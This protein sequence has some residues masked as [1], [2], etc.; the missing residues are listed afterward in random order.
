MSSLR[1]WRAR[2]ARPAAPQ[3]SRAASAVASASSASAAARRSA[4]RTGACGSLG[5][6]G[7]R[8]SSCPSRPSASAP[9]DAV[10]TATSESKEATRVVGRVRQSGSCTFTSRGAVEYIQARAQL[11]LE[12]GGVGAGHAGLRPAPRQGAQRLEV[13]AEPPGGRRQRR[14]SRLEGLPGPAPDQRRQEA[15]ARSLIR[16]L[17]RLERLIV[18]Q[19]G[20]NSASKRARSRNRNHAKFVSSTL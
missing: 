4:T 19:Q 13:R 18:Q 7:V 16:L 9:S 8:R 3:A 2:A 14:A 20:P 11:A 17:E 6:T 1:S 15:G 12:R 10:T 5:P